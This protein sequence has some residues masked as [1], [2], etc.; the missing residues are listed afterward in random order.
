MSDVAALITALAALLTA[1]TTLVVTLRTRR[2]V[3]QV[4][5]MVNQQRTDAQAYQADLVA[6]LHRAGVVV[7]RDQSLPAE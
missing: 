1:G 6:A 5:T 4:H 2:A 7:P 3:E